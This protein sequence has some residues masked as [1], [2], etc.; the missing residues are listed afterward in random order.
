MVGTPVTSTVRA[1]AAGWSLIGPASPS[2]YGDVQPA[3][4]TTPTTGITLPV[5]GFVGGQYRSA[6]VL[7]CGQAYWLYTTSA[8]NL[9]LGPVATAR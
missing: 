3:W 6:T 9:E 2:P 5:Y 8:T 4:L 1:V 7:E